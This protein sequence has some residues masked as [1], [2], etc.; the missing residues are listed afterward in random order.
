MLA[1]NAR[2]FLTPLA[3]AALLCGAAA[4]GDTAATP[5]AAPS[6]S[7]TA[8]PAPAT[9]EAPPATT[10]APT[11]AIPKPDRADYPG[12]DQHTEDGAIQAYRYFWAMT[13]WAHQTGEVEEL[14]SLHSEACVGC[15]ENL[16]SIEFMRSQGQ[17]WVGGNLQ[18]L[19]D[20]PVSAY[21][22]PLNEVEVGYDFIV[23]ENTEPGG[24]GST[25][26]SG[27]VFMQT[28]GGMN[29]ENGAWVLSGYNTE[30]QPWEGS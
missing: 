6:A 2:R 21:D 5:S 7:P 17:F 25:A 8:A 30:V 13:I 18:E 14:K 1:K 12:M 3:A 20:H 27:A 26:H 9:S 24:D 15:A 29:W 19:P 22:S 23:R 10:A 11:P 16:E 4:C 28:V